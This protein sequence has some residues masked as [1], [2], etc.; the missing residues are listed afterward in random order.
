MSR[1]G[2]RRRNLEQGGFLFEVGS[3]TMNRPHLCRR[4]WRLGGSLL[5]TSERSAGPLTA[6]DIDHRC[7]LGVHPRGD[8]APV[9]P[10]RVGVGH[11]RIDGRVPHPALEVRQSRSVRCG[12]QSARVANLVAPHTLV[13]QCPKP[14]AETISKIARLGPSRCAARDRPLP[15]RARMF[16]R[17]GASCFWRV[18][19]R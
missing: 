9:V 8:A 19:G 17:I 18:R 1:I 14:P 2:R 5:T 12:Q 15:Q 3:T 13:A 11:R 7:A 10:G 4:P 16:T 6:V